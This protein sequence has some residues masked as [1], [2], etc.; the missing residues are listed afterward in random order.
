METRLQVL[1][2]GTADVDDRDLEANRAALH[3]RGGGE[4][5]RLEGACMPPKAL[6]RLFSFYFTRLYIHVRPGARLRLARRRP[7]ARA[8][9][10]R[11]AHGGGALG[12]RRGASGAARRSRRGGRRSGT[13]AWTS[14]ARA[15]RTAVLSL[16]APDGFPFSVRVPIR[17]TARRAA[18]G[19]AATRSACRC[20]PGSRASP[21]TTTRPTSRGSGTSRCAATS[22]RRTAAGPRAAADGGRLRAA[23]GLEAAALPMNAGKM[24]RSGARQK[25]RDANFALEERAYL[26]PKSP[27]GAASLTSS[28][29]AL[30]A[31]VRVSAQE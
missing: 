25:K 16:V 6:Q 1:V 28:G 14:S 18:S 30:C 17:S 15:T 13:S 12:P 5:A 9:A 3:A 31:S 19:S 8:E 22:S 7:H 4:A 24:V 21:P 10:V 20:S 29:F 23:A 27:G 11:R 2:Q 26:R